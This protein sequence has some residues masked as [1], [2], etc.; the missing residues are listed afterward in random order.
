MNEFLVFRG[1]ELIMYKSVV[2][3]GDWE[4]RE[5]YNMYGFY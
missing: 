4:Y 1:F 5:F 2:Y 3:Y